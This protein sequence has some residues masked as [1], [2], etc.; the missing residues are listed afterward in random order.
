MFNYNIK[1][2]INNI[3]DLKKLALY[4]SLLIDEPIYFYFKGCIGV[5]KS[6]FCKEIIFNILN[7]NNINNNINYIFNSSSFNIISEYKY[8]IYNL[9]HFDFYNIK[10][11][12]E[13]FDLEI[14]NYFN[15]EN[16]CLV[17]WPDNFIKILPISDLFF[18]F[19]FINNKKRFI[20][21]KSF[22]KLGNKILNLLNFSK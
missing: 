14:D 8:K 13:L 20:Y 5:G 18:Y 9:Y 11:K 12:L 6:V 17:E 10:N 7:Y 15:R 1:I 19:Y 21:I 16:I 22:S 2:N 3:Y 4:I